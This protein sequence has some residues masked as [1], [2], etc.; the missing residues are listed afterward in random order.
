M[1][2]RQGPVAGVLHAVRADLLRRLDRPAEAAAE[3]ARAAGLMAS[4]AERACLERRRREIG[5]TT[6]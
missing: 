6:T 2:S 1:T 4:E 3:Y 5:P